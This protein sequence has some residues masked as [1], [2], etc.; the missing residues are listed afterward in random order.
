MRY[1]IGIDSGGTKTDSVLFDGIG[2]VLCRRRDSG[3]N[4]YDIGT[5]AS[6]EKLHSIITRLTELS[7]ERVSSI[8]AGVAGMIDFGDIIAAQLREGIGIQSIEVG[9]DA[10]PL[11]N[12]V[13]ERS[14]GCCVISGTGVSCFIRSGGAIERIGGW[15]Y[16]LDGGGGGYDLGQDAIAAVLREYDGQGGETVLSGLL[17]ARMGGHPRELICKIYQGG[18]AYVASFADVVFEGC[19]LGDGVSLEI[20][21]RNAEA[22]AGLINTARKKQPFLNTVALGG[23]VFR[24]NPE[25]AAKLREL[26]SGRINLTVNS[27]PSV[28]GAA[29]EAVYISGNQIPH[30]FRDN[31]TA[32]CKCIYI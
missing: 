11:L 30:G 9:S 13:F 7:P 12:C 19:R 4:P 23:G 20:M 31:F 16:M 22:V 24:H 8:F 14:G 6:S 2:R 21:T 28:Y 17:A 1:Y 10:I 32:T 15:G 18:R 27:M 29:L 25:Y 5:E 26:V 3:C